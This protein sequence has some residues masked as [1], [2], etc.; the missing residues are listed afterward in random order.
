MDPKIIAVPL[1]VVLN[2]LILLH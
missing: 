1:V 2:G